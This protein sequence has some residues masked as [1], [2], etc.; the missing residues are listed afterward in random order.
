VN[1]GLGEQSLEKFLKYNPQGLVPVLEFNGNYYSQ[2]LAIIELIEE[3]NPDRPLLPKNKMERAQVR[4]FAHQIAMEIHPL[5]NL[6]V[7]KYLENE[8]GLNETKKTSWYLHWIEEGFRSLEKS[9]RNNDCRTQFCFGEIPSLADIC[10]IPQ[11]YNGLRFN[12]NIS[13]YPTIKSIWDH[14]MSLDEFKRAAPESQ[15]DAQ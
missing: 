1:L 4:S 6:R 11:V 13:E 9:L 12:C 3:M 2:S 10:L 15:P 8:L 14:C 5:N 7:L